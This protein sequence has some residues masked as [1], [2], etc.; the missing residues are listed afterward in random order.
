MSIIL[1]NYWLV[2]PAFLSGTLVIA[3]AGSATEVQQRTEQTQSKAL[4]LSDIKKSSELRKLNPE[5]ELKPQYAPVRLKSTDEQVRALKATSV[6]INPTSKQVANS[7][8]VTNNSK[9]P[10]P[11]ATS[12]TIQ[13]RSD[14]SLVKNEGMAPI[15]SEQNT[16][17]QVLP[18]TGNTTTNPSEVLEQI[19]RYN[20][21]NNEESSAGPL[22][23]ITNVTQLTDVKPSDWAYE[24][25]RSLVERYGCIQGYPDG[26]FR[27]NRATSRY[28]FAAGLNACLNQIERLIASNTADLV[29]KQDLE[30]LR[31]LVEE[32]RT[33]LTALGG[34]V[35]KLEG[36][37]AFLEEHQ[38]STTTRLNGEVIVGVSE[39][40]GNRDR[41]GNNYSGTNAVIQNRVRL[42]FDTSFT[43]KDR[44]RTR[45]Q[46][47]SVN[48][49]GPLQA[50]PIT[51][52]GT[53]ITREGLLSFAGTDNPANGVYISN[54][55]YRF[56]VGKQALVQLFAFSDSFDEIAP[57]LNAL[58]NAAIGSISW[59]GIRSP[60]YRIGAGISGAGGAVTYGLSGPIR[61]DLGY[62]A[63]S[64]T[65]ATLIGK[66]SDPGED[67]GLFN[68]NYSAIGQL[69][70][71]PNRKFRIAATYVQTYDRRSLT[72]NAGSVASQLNA[73]R[74]IAGNT[75]GVEATFAFSP[76]FVL[77]GWAAYTKGIVLGVGTADVW[78]YAATLAINDLG[79]KGNTLGFVVGMEP[80]LTGTS[81]PAV[82]RLISGLSA[83]TRRD[84]DTG[85][86]VEGFYRFAVTN[87]ISIT[88]GVIW[89]TAPG[90]NEGNDDILIGVLRTS[91]TF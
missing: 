26:T 32:F 64:S 23:Q 86:H 27:G 52:P 22:D 31:R 25:L 30:T 54:L 38:F 48:A 59:F 14:Q 51:G 71:Q 4:E 57:T 82:A 58:E 43:G 80:K 90:H 2:I 91:F 6:R 87:N 40:F 88:P 3:I 81:S 74:P 77:S 29:R 24:A 78:N 37:V 67:S 84:R 72:T 20:G 63:Q 34:R 5:S 55:N 44:L 61:V 79:K 49:F 66:S 13:A 28:E 68:G 17:A 70:F 15:E 42:N 62:L 46:A 21:E 75:Y 9:Q 19:Q 85:L 36:R 33:E 35:N 47:R 18:T 39:L 76:Q 73:G 50:A 10:K 45:L 1:W 41:L 60:I 16:L 56:P 7:A 8:P 65:N 83:G 89:L 11:I 53:N 12:E 69:T